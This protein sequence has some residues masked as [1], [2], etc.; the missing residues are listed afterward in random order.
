MTLEYVECGRCYRPFHKMGDL[1][2]VLKKSPKAFSYYDTGIPT[3][4]MRIM[5]CTPCLEEFK[6]ALNERKTDS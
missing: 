2:E 6:E 4:I 1:N 3:K 5:M